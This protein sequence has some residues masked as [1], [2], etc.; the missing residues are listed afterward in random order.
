MKN[1]YRCLIITLILSLLFIYPA[2]ADINI[3]TDIRIGLYYGSTARSEVI[4]S[5]TSDVICGTTDGAVQALEFNITP[6]ETGFKIGEYK[7]V[8]SQIELYPTEGY[9]SVNKKPYRGYIRLI[10]SGNRITVINVVN[11]E[12]YL[13]G[14]LP[15]EMSTG[16]PIEALKSQAICART[17][18]ASNMGRFESYGFDLTD[19]TL[20]QVYG[21]V[22]SEKE[23]C[24]RA[25]DE[26]KGMVVTYN[27]KIASTF[28]FATSSGTTLDVKDVWGSSG[29]PYLVSVDDSLQSEVIKNNGPW[30]V[31][32]T[33][34]EINNLISRKGLGI[35]E[36]KDISAEYN[37]QGAVMKLILTGSEGT[38]VYQ[39]E[40]ARTFF[41]VRSQV[42]TIV[43]NSDSAGSF[44]SLGA[45]GF[46]SIGADTAV[47][48]AEGTST[49][50]SMKVLTANGIEFIEPSA[51]FD[52]IT[53]NGYGNGH[54]IGMSQNGAKAMAN[55][56]Y[57]Y[58]KI[59]TH[60]FTGV[61]ITSVY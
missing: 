1:A 24:T 4:I 21:G 49:V 26:T 23:D 17:Y 12:E 36:I 20:S 2:E 15:H 59:I 34:E 55:A 30:K 39:R 42:F 61:D 38:K 41:G 7:E 27:G 22:S 46:N 16:W 51:S 52:S 28:Y 56:G 11:L 44:C 47:L 37:E 43:K 57:T 8:Q 25:V 29:Y 60:Y 48:S 40:A 18:S 35:G 13:Y 19:N 6:T 14:V 54:G 3:P 9:I 31:T 5:G 45:G 33:K 58:D 32:F 50:G 10:N 53:L